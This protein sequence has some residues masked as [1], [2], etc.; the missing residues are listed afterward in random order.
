MNSIAKFAGGSL[1]GGCIVYFAMAACSGG[2][3]GGGV[4]PYAEAQTP[5]CNHYQVVSARAGDL[6]ETGETV[7]I[8]GVLD[9]PVGWEPFAYRETYPAY[10]LRRCVP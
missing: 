10:M 6:Q 2:G 8:D 1:I 9:V 5:T 4:V 7:G 3:S